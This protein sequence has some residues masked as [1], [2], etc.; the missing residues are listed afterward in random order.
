MGTS[1]LIWTGGRIVPADTPI[2]GAADRALVHGLGLFETF[3]TWGGRPLLLGRHLARL[4][5]SARTLGIKVKPRSLPAAHDVRALIGA[6]GFEGRDA[7]LR[8]TLSGG[9]DEESPAVAWLAISEL[10]EHTDRGFLIDL[11][12]GGT[13]TVD[14]DDPLTRH[15]TLNYWSKRSA[16]DR[17]RRLGLDESLSVTP[18][19]WFWE[20][21]T[22]NLFLVIGGEILTPGP[23]GPFLPGIMRGLVRERA[24]AMG[25]PVRE[26][27]VG[28]RFVAEADEVFLTNAVRGIVPVGRVG[29]KPMPTPGVLTSWLI[30]EVGSVLD[31]SA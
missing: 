30:H 1:D 28:A 17:A 27:R 31:G 9:T 6:T 22:T 2:L 26:R 20:G 29:T 12:D 18:D 5:G 13:W 4:T 10:P 24:A 11:S 25:L 23:D 15:K 19:G 14:P 7:R 16:L 8:L 21:S 3:R